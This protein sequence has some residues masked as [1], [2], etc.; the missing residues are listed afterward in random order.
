MALESSGTMSIGGSTSGRS[1]NLE[2]GR[3][4]TATSSLN[5]SDLRSL[6]EVSSGAISI[7]NFYGKSDSITYTGHPLNNA[8][9]NGCADG[10][11]IDLDYNTGKSQPNTA[12]TATFSS[13]IPYSTLQVI[14]GDAANGQLGTVSGA[15]LSINGSTV[16]AQGMISSNGYNGSY[17]MSYTA[18]NGTLN[19]IGISGGQIGS[20]Q[21]YIFAIIID[22]S[23]L[24]ATGPTWS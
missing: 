19:S 5:E 17:H 13:G 21:A 14:F 1:I 12:G 15:Q 24:N 7:S 18:S 10:G 23:M 16:T 4:A 11:T 3:S 9:G 20:H 2:L 22:G 6:A 8:D